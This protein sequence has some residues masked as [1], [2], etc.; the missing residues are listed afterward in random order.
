MSLLN[1]NYPTH[2][3]LRFLILFLLILPCHGSRA[4]SGTVYYASPLVY[5]KVGKDILV[6]SKI[7][8]PGSKK[9]LHLSLDQKTID[10]TRSAGDT[11]QTWLPLVGSAQI[12]TITRKGAPAISEE[13]QPIIP[14]DWGYFKHGT[15]HIIVSSHQDIAWMNTPAYCREERIHDIILPALD[16][17]REHKDYR[18]EMEQTL[19]LQELLNEYPDKNDEVTKAYQAGQFEWGA[20]FNQPY[21]GI[22]SGEQLTRQLYWGR[23]WIKD[24][25]PGM[26]ARTA[27]NVD[28]PGRSMQFPQVLQKGGVHN[29]VISRFGEGFYN[30]YSPD[31]SSVFTYSPG[32]Y[33]WVVAVNKY[34]EKQAPYAMHDLQNRLQ[35]W[36]EYY[37]S[38]NIP[39]DYGVMISQDASGPVYYKDVIAE[40]NNIVKLSDIPLPT[41][42][43]STADEF[44]KAVNVAGA[45]I[46]SISGER[47][48]IW[49]YIHG[50]GHYE[51]IK[52]KKEAS[53]YLPAAEIFSTF[54]GVLNNTL[55]AYP[56]ARFDSAWFNAIYPDHGWGGMNGGITDSIFNARLHR[57]ASEGKAM[58]NIALHGIAKNIKI[59]KPG[60]QVV[61][62]DLNWSRDMVA[63]IA[64]PAGKAAYSVTD[65]AG[66][67]V[68]SQVENDTLYFLAKAVPA[69][70]YRVF[71]LKKGGKKPAAK[72]TEGVNYFEN[73]F[74]KVVFG[75]GGIT[76]LYDRVLKQEILNTTKFSGG[77]VLA[78]GYAGNG[79]G[80]FNEMTKPN[81]MNFDKLSNH[82]SFWKIVASGPV[83]TTF[84]CV[85]EMNKIEIIQRIT[86]YNQVKKIDFEY[87]I[88]QW[89]GRHNRQWR[90]ALGVNQLDAAIQY[91]SPYGVATVDQD[92]LPISP[93][94][95]S[96]AGNYTQLSK[97]IHPREVLDF[98]SVNGKDYGVTV[99]GTASVVDWI[100]P[101]RDAARYPVIQEVMI[102]THKSCHG[103]GPFYEQPGRHVFKFSLTS[104]HTGWENGYT[105]G[106]GSQHPAFVVSADK[107]VH[108]TLPQTLSFFKTST[109]FATLSTIKKSD[110]DNDIIVRLAEMSGKDSEVTVEMHDAVVK[111]NSTS[112]IEEV[113]APLPAVSGKAFKLSLPKSGVET[114]KLNLHTSQP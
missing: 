40:W 95:W 61:F 99:S 27:Y 86:I 103:M 113:R 8:L 79:A 47:P 3:R 110:A 45:K 85:Y 19:N 67:V 22:E 83:A 92:E 98:V 77:D 52:A 62:N 6:Q 65:D 50:P 42:R 30:W 104:H 71:Y 20:T 7:Y 88:P 96:W 82:T 70:G 21:E 31:G 48:N 91:E 51:A 38:R 64:L 69:V 89:D 53:V 2:Y 26:D 100:D 33:G 16:I 93:G 9:G 28:V 14:A 46:D 54:S 68:P 37:S 101:T 13:F 78:L 107:N 60:A 81:E 94:G 17:M 66:H 59:Q 11:L 58:L 76:S 109:P 32:N 111:A 57:A 74:Y 25:L 49:M 44:L 34:F 75:N 39:P 5:K 102:S 72:I 63:S 84:A 18:F 114:F 97:F 112:L 12:L 87:E 43:H 24:N 1:S 106:K 105:F 29:L 108:A 73:D 4:Q 15:I 80:E 55:T 23:K 10:Y 41:L 36:N 56:K 35:D 90:F